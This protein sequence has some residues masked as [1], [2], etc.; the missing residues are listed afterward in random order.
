MVKVR[1]PDLAKMNKDSRVV[2]DFKERSFKIFVYDHQGK[3]YD[4]G[5]P[6]L[7]CRIKP[8]ECSYKLCEKHLEVTLIS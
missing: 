4:F 3:N 6:K 7:Q 8:Q 5:V 1:L 2:T